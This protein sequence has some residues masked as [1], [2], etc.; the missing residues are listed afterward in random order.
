[1]SGVTIQASSYVQANQ[2]PFI[3]DKIYKDIMKRTHLRNKFMDFKTDADRIAYS[4]QGNYCVSL[5]RKE[6]KSYCS[7]LI[8]RDVT[9]NK[10]FWRK[11]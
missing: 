11:V 6:K 3:N 1:M 2:A 9:D 5:I 8:I 4:K 7:N 10:T